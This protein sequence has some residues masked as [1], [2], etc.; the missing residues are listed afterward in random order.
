MPGLGS[1]REWVTILPVQLA[2]PDATG[3][4][5]ESWPDPPADTTRHAAR[6]DA[7][8]GGE[9]AAAPRQTFRTHTLRFRCEVPLTAADRVEI[10][11]TTY[12]VTGAWRERA[13]EGR[14]FQTVATL[15][16]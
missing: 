9:T 14:G 13:A 8:A 15:V 1:Y 10:D 11:G 5:V 3:E 16:G 12:G 2:A 7:A 4:E 6:F